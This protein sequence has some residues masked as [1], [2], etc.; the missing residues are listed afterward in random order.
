[1][2][3]LDG[4]AL[5]L[6]SFDRPAQPG[7][8][9][10]AG[11]LRRM[12]LLNRSDVQGLLQEYEAAQSALQLQVASQFPNVTLGPGYTYDQGD[13]KYSLDVS[14]ELPIFNRNQGP[15]AEAQASRT[16]AVARFVALQARIIGAIDAATA[17]YRAASDT[18]STAD[19]LLN[20]AEGRERQIARSFRAGQI[21][22]PTLVT[23]QLESAA[24]RLSRLDAAVQQRQALGALED[25]LQQPLFEPGRWPYVPE[26]N[27]RLTGMEPS[28]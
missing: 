1:M 18:L 16:E 28:S 4:V 23:A 14:A 6:D 10:M 2:R 27:P 22:R 13:N 15:I 7:H 12:A 25:A 8:Q 21:D 9:A 5:S 24:A 3:A 11:Q 26:Q 20:G 19:A 17:S